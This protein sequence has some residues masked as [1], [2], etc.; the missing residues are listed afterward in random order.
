MESEKK[1]TYFQEFLGDGC[2][3]FLSSPGSALRPLDP[4]G[5]SSKVNVE[6]LLSAVLGIPKPPQKCK[7]TLGLPLGV[8]RG[9]CSAGNGSQVKELACT[10]TL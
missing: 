9:P 3:S 6:L 7:G 4:N 2:V 10:L 8:L 1:K 5:D